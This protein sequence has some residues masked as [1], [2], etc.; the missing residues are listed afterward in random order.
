MSTTTA[1][2][3]HTAPG[4]L[5]L[6]GTKK[7][8]FATLVR[9]E[10]RK[11]VDTRAGLWLLITTG[12]FAALGMGILL[13]VGLT[14]DLTLEF[15]TFFATTSYTTGVLLPVLGILLVTSEWSQRTAMVTFTTEP[16]RMLVVLAKLVAGL[17]LALVVAVV[18][19]GIAAVCNLLYGAISGDPV[20]WSLGDVSVGG[21]LVTQGIAMLAGFA[22]ATIMLSTPAAIVL[23]FVY[24]FVLPAV[25]GIGAAFVGW[26][27]DIQPWLDFTSAQAPLIDWSLDGEDWAHLAVSGT[28]WLVLPLALGLWR[29]LRAEVK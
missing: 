15:G 18:A 1:Q 12:L 27:Q 19:T 2:P 6:S 7:I 26:I 5:D 22:L 3:G 28:V 24:T 16:R 29:I 13:A 9:V 10:L 21:F 23:F 4:T 8:G 17:L 11:A 20:S 25:F 14:E